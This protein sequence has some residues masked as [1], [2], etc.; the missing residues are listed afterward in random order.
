VIV[1]DLKDRRA[2]SYPWSTVSLLAWLATDGDVQ[3]V[4][5]PCAAIGE[6]AAHPVWNR[7][8]EELCREIQRWN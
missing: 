7:S 6:D 8:P 3:T 5:N 2:H 4:G 1:Y